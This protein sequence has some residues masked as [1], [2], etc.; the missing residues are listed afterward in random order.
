MAT[1]AMIRKNNFYP[2]VFDEF[3]KP[4]NSWFDNE[5][6][7]ARV[8]TAP[9]VNITENDNDYQLS[10]GVPGMRKDDFN[11]DVEG[12]VLTVSSEKEESSEEKDKKYTRK[13]FSYA[14][15]SR[16]FALPE[17]VAQEKITASYTDGTLKIVLPKKE[18]SR[19]TSLLRNISVQ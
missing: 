10:I 5:L 8:L 1:N 9:P 19:K 13:E 14:S 7:P 4:W 18:E 16:S 17:E 12:N 3:V 2:S 6:I 11:I 15:F